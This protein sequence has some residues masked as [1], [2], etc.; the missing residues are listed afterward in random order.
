MFCGRVRV[1]GMA[2][3]VTGAHGAQRG[4]EA[5]RVRGAAG[6]AWLRLSCRLL[7]SA[8]LWQQEEAEYQSI[9]TSRARRCGCVVWLRPHTLFLFL[10]FSLSCTE[11]VSSI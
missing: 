4:E 11:D 8:V 7:L 2:G 5:T 10:G 3:M 6:D 9:R 1:D